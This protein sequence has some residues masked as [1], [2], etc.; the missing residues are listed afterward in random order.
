MGRIDVTCPLAK[1]SML[2][3]LEI[4]GFIGGNRE[5]ETWYRYYLPDFM[6][7]RISR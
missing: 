7:V 6:Y 3:S 1:I 4:K 5:N 2:R